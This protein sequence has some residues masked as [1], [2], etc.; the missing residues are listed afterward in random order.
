MQTLSDDPDRAV[1]LLEQLRASEGLGP[2]RFDALLHR[3]AALRALVR[4]Q[5]N[6]TNDAARRMFDTV[7]GPKR[8]ARLM[9]LP[10]LG[11]AREA[12]ERMENGEFF[13]DVAVELS[14]DASASRGGLLEPISRSDGSYPEVLRK[15]LFDLET[16]EISRPILINDQYALL[17]LV[18]EIEGDDVDF[19]DVRDDMRRRV[20][21][22]QQRALMD[23]QARSMMRNIKVT[24]FDESLNA[25]WRMSRQ[26]RP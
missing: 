16:G 13:G 10:T 23:Q 5:V 26:D 17:E 9:I 20:R 18:R 2:V 11:V 6:V 4:D 3:N 15:T 19:D 1:R 14:S 12:T 25:S 8:Q 21:L 24:I 22:Q 7:H